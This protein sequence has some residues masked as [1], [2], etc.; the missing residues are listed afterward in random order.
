MK[1]TDEYIFRVD[2]SAVFIKRCRPFTV[3]FFY[4]LKKGQR[5][6]YSKTTEALTPWS[7]V[8]I[9]PTSGEQLPL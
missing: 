1:Y 6:L 8:F 9:A 5:T 7:E 3:L 4:M 2:I